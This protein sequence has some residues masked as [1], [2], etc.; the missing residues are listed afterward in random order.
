MGGRDKFRGVEGQ[1]EEKEGS[2][3]VFQIG[4][5]EGVTVEEDGD[6]E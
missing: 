4:V 3:H 6:F 5:N 2:R 1:V